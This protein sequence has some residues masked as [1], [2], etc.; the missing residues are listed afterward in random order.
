MEGSGRGPEDG[1]SAWG[2][3]GRGH[4]STVAPVGGS[5]PRAPIQ[6]T[7]KRICCRYNLP[8]GECAGHGAG[9]AR[10]ESGRLLQR[11]DGDVGR[12]R[13]GEVGLRSEYWHRRRLNSL[14]GLSGRREREEQQRRYVLAL[15]CEPR[16]P[17]DADSAS[18]GAFRSKSSPQGAP[19]ALRMPSRMRGPPCTARRTWGAC[20]PRRARWTAMRRG[21]STMPSCSSARPRFLTTYRA[22]GKCW[23]AR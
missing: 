12:R 19:R 17:W 16:A 4:A 11:R 1:N 10:G 13:R 2:D 7:L 23:G 5:A 6:A 3:G 15:A 20:L 8:F 9:G 18:L 21:S 22:T 14:P